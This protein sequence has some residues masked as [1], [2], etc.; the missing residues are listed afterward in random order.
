M[1]AG[2]L[3]YSAITNYGKSTLPSVESWGTNMNILKD[4][5]KS[6][7]T[8]RITKVGQL[9]DITA[10][11]GE[12]GDRACEA[13]THYARGV[14]PMVSVSYSNNSNNGG[15]SLA[16]RSQGGQA[17]L[18]YRV[19]RDGAFRPP[20]RRAE[21]LMPLSRQPRIWTSAFTKPGF[22][23][24]SKKMKN[25]GT[26]EETKEVKNNLLKCSA[27]PTAVFTMQTPIEQPYEVKYVI[28]NPTVVSANS[29]VRTLDYSNTNVIKPGSKIIDNNMHVF[30]NANTSNRNN[31][32]NNSSKNIEPYMQDNLNVFAN[33]NYSDKN[34]YVN[35]NS[36]NVDPYMQDNLNV[37][38][39]A[40][41]SDKAKYTNNNFME[42]ERYLQDNINSDI[43]V[44]ANSSS[45]K[46]VT[47][48]DEVIDLSGIKIQEK[49]NI[50]YQTPIS[51][52][53]EKNNYVH[54]PKKLD[55][56]LPSHIMTTNKAQ[57]IYKKQEHT[58]EIDLERNTPLTNVYTSKATN[59]IGDADVS[60]RT[61]KLTPKIVAG[62]YEG[63]GSRPLQSTSRT[64][65]N[66]DNSRKLNMNRSINKQFQ[67]Y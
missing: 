17:F 48:I 45:N 44:V 27:R 37:F 14:N 39:N 30:A 66:L 24:F 59:R 29:G 67:R 35:N 42:T 8:R 33:V 26:A 10:T 62:G 18:P 43:N 46:W 32:V 52:G 50:T 41:P 25:C 65:K 3:S 19:M 60:S 40:N 36:K 7:H 5:P 4:P 20:V 56:V 49:Y 57:N 22:T 61:Y 12:S 23:D 31:Y 28:Q 6:I 21:D 51:G 55:R 9:S 34:N 15:K 16:Q 58:N 1:S 38:A 11:I 63:R 13:I 2:G 47:P 64:L 54:D 53:S